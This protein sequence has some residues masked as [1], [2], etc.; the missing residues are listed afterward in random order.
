[1]RSRLIS[2]A[3]KGENTTAMSEVE[4]LRCEFISVAVDRL[5]EPLHAL[6]LALHAVVAGYTGELNDQQ[7]EMLTDA[8][9]AAGRLEEIMDDLLELAEIESGTRHLFTQRMRPIDLARMAVERFQAAADCKH[10]KL[11]NKVWPD[12]PWVMADPQAIKSVFDNLLSNAIRHT[13]R[14]GVI[15]IEAGE[16]AD[17]VYFSVSDTGEGIPEAYL[18]TLFSRFVHVDGRPG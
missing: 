15:K 2:P 10:I 6:Q 16:R 3:V 1:M 13:R 17:R 11:E 8:R 12:L 14:D 4:R 7:T 5:R 18:P 9:Q